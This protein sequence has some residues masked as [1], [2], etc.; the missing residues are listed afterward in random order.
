MADTITPQQIAVRRTWQTFL[1]GL[2]ID[3]VVAVA[4][5]IIAQLD[6]ITDT[7]ALW[8]FAVSIGKTV[9]IAAAQYVVRTF[10]IKPEDDAAVVLPRRA[11]ASDDS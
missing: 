4:L 6:R 8:L 10:L 7:D 9:V 11:L 5:L 2:A 3:V 1:S